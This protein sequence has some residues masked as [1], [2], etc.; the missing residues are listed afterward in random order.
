MRSAMGIV[1]AME[2]EPHGDSA[3]ARTT[4]RAS[5]A[6]RMTIIE[7]TAMSAAAPPTGPISSRAICPSVFPF[8]L[9]EKK[10]V[11]MSDRK[12]TRLNSSHAN[13]SYAVFCLKKKGMQVSDAFL[14]SCCHRL[15]FRYLEPR[16]AHRESDICVR[17]EEH[18]SQLHSPQYL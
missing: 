4:T 9:I 3:R 7:R 8:L 1:I 6:S 13:I 16:T 12:S 17:S 5:T 2:N 10:S 15:C 14:L 18:T 11:V